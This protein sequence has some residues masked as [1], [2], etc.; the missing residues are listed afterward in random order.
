M[1]DAASW[2]G[3]SNKTL[4]VTLNIRDF[5]FDVINET[6]TNITINLQKLDDNN[7]WTNF[8]TAPPF[9]SESPKSLV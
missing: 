7:E 6:I 3:E 9:N 4:D 1:R 8:K 2:V 5:G